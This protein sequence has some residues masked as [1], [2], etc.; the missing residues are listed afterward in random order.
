MPSSPLLELCCFIF[1]AMAGN[2]LHSIHVLF[3]FL[4]SRSK[5]KSLIIS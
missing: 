2:P 5:F 1:S 4:H 3:C